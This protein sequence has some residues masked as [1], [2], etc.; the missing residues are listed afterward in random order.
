[1]AEVLLPDAL[2]AFAPGDIIHL[3]SKSSYIDIATAAEMQRPGYLDDLTALWRSEFDRLAQKAKMPYDMA[4]RLCDDPAKVKQ[5]KLV[6]EKA[7]QKKKDFRP[8]N[9]RKVREIR[10]RFQ[11][12]GVILLIEGDEVG[13]FWFLSEKRGSVVYEE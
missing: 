13:H 11:N 8:F 10:Q 1:M 3:G 7:E 9:E 12:D 2:M 6:A 5:A 4:R